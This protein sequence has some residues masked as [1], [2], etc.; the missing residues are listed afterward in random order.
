MPKALNILPKWRNLAKSGHTEFEYRRITHSL[1]HSL[2]VSSFNLSTFVIHSSQTL[3][4]TLVSRHKNKTWH[5][6]NFYDDAISYFEYVLWLNVMLASY[7]RLIWT[8][9]CTCF[10]NGHS[11]L[12]FVLFLYFLSNLHTIKVVDCSGIRTRT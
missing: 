11:R 10:L 4:S 6:I 8:F 2:T 12:L 9:F 3:L 1:T 7:L 5:E